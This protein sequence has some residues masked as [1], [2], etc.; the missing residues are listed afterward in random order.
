MSK[1]RIGEIASDLLVTPLIPTL[2]LAAISRANIPETDRRDFS[3]II[4][5]FQNYATPSIATFLSETQNT[6]RT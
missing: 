6:A 2:Q 3:I 4:D 1:G 5:E